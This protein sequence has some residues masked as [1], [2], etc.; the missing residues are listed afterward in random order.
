MNNNVKIS[1]HG[2]Y[3]YSIVEDG[4]VIHSNPW[5]NNTILSA[6]LVDLYDKSID[7]L[8]YYLDLGLSS[9]QPGAAGYGLSGVI[10]SS[11]FAD[12]ERDGIESYNDNSITRTFV[13]NFTTAKSLSSY[14]LN[15]FAIKR[16]KNAPAFARNT[17]LEPIVIEPNQYINFEYKLSLGWPSTSTH[18]IPITGNNTSY[19]YSIPVTSVNYNIPYY[20][21]Y[22]PNNY[23]LLLGDIYNEENCRVYLPAQG[24]NYPKNFVWGIQQ[25]AYS[26][27]KPTEIYN[28]ID[29]STKTYNVTTRYENIKCPLNS[30]VFSNIQYALLLHN[31]NFNIASNKFNITKFAYP[32]TVY[33][34]T[35]SCDGNTD[36]VSSLPRYNNL[37]IDY[38]YSWSECESIPAVFTIPNACDINI[39]PIPPIQG[40]CNISWSTVSYDLSTIDDGQGGWMVPQDEQP[41]EVY[42]RWIIS[43]EG[44]TIRFNIQDSINCGGTNGSI[45]SGTATAIIDVVDDDF[46]L[47]INFSGMAEKYQS[48]FENIEF[49]LDEILILS[50]TSPGNT[51]EQLDCGV[52]PVVQ[53]IIVPPPYTLQSGNQYTL[54]IEFTTSDPLYH[55]DAYYQA[56][57]TCSPV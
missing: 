22:S 34:Q 45:Q 41:V 43:N 13:T 3:R 38:N 54:R 25:Q 53:T 1:L 15:E 30:G 32:L 6:G 28:G 5:C 16:A 9:D 47:G 37:S 48:G 42:N 11:V 35:L 17:F 40:A 39:P 4:Q 51:Q 44:R 33:N 56:D 55:K 24:E 52:G 23:L 29:Q 2:Q 21:V 49:Y 36:V 8:L 7:S 14:T 57:F 12:I 26:T 20:S 27:Y 10:S 19:T 18:S 31:N 46:N 50:A